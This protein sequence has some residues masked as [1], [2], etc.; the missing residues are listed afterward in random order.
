MSK[1]NELGKNGEKI[2]RQFLVNKGHKILAINFRF[3]HKEI[4]IISAVGDTVVFSEIKTRSSLHF[5]FPEEAVTATKQSLIKS[6]AEHFLEEHPGFL[7][8]RFDVI[9]IVL[10]DDKLIQIRHYKDAFC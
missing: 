2:A 4:D 6:A 9:S 5:G 3:G 1:H 8:C 10:N 7:Q